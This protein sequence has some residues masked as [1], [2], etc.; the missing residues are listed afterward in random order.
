MPHY[1]KLAGDLCYLSPCSADDAEKWAQWETDLAVSLPLGDEAYVPTSLERARASLNETL[2]NREH[3]FT[4]VDRATDDAIGR[5]MLFAVDHVNRSAML[6]ILIGET[7]Y[8]GRG[9]G[10]EATRLLVEYGIGLLNLNS[11]ML[12]TYAFNARAL[13]CYERVGFREIGRRRQARVIGGAKVDAI[14]MDILAEELEFRFINR[15]FE[16]AGLDLSP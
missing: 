10:Q 4:I 7:E 9:Y 2:A 12:G 8:W 11:I 1:K 13:H 16:A 14:L 3:V 6:G 5:G 15:V